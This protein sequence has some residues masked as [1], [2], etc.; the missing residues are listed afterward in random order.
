MSSVRCQGSRSL[1]LLGLLC[2]GL[3]CSQTS[4]WA[5]SKSRPQPKPP[6]THQQNL[7]IQVDEE[8]VVRRL[9]PLPQ[10]DDKG[11]PKKPTTEELKA[12]KGPD[13][14]LPG[15]AAEFSDLK[16]GQTVLLTLGRVRAASPSTTPTK[17]KTSSSDADAA[18]GKKLVFA[19]YKDEMSGK[20]IRVGTPVPREMDTDKGKKKSQALK[21]DTGVTSTNMLVNVTIPGPAPPRAPGDNSEPSFGP[22]IYVIRI[23]IVAEGDG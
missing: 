14:K 15:Y 16:P 20:V 1:K 19:R 7:G 2:L 3:A 8:V 13:P 4:A 6:E 21:A 23:M 11:K 5:Q 12:L 9:T 22:E 18:K 10:F 17:T